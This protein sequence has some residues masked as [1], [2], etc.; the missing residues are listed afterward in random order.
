MRFLTYVDRDNSFYNFPIHKDDI[1]LMPDKEKIYDELN[2]AELSKKNMYFS[3]DGETTTDIKSSKNLEDFWIASV[4]HTLYEKYV[5]DYTKKMWMIDDNK[6]IDNFGWSPKGVTIK[7][8]DKNVWDNCISAYPIKFNGY[9]DWF[10]IATSE[11]KNYFD[12]QIEKYDLENN[13]VIINGE[14]YTFYILIN[15]Y[16]LIYYLKPATVS[17]HILAEI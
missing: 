4:G 5:K 1:E 14:K 11:T 6:I 8:G 16:H 17:F 7:E 15:P 3:P 2:K 10:D 9:N 13:A 12:T